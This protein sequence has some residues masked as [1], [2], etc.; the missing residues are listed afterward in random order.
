MRVRGSGFR[1]Q[2]NHKNFAQDVSFR[3]R[4][5]GFR[6]RFGV[7]SEGFWRPGF[8]LRLQ[9]VDFRLQGAGF[10]VQG[11]GFRATISLLSGDMFS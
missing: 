9:G 7:K 10:R 11:A 4:V 5:L 6:S 2:G 3:F 1:V 8:V